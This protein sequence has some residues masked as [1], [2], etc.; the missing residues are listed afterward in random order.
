MIE[1]VTML[2]MLDSNHQRSCKETPFHRYDSYTHAATSLRGATHI[3][4]I[5]TPTRLSQNI[6]YQNLCQ[7]CAVRAISMQV[8]CRVAESKRSS[9]NVVGDRHP[10]DDGCRYCDHYQ[11]MLYG[12]SHEEIRSALQSWTEQGLSSEEDMSDPVQA[13]EIAGGDLDDLGWP[14]TVL[15]F[16]AAVRDLAARRLRNRARRQVK[17]GRLSQTSGASSNSGTTAG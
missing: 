3:L 16:S 12:H 1:R 5:S 17:R 7:T 2:T 14:S 4:Q 9:P 15:G 11:N 6:P 13:V 8:K 10:L